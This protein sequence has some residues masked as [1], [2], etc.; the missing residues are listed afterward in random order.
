MK[1]PENTSYYFFDQ[2]GAVCKPN[3]GW[4]SIK[5]DNY[6]YW[7]YIR[8]ENQSEIVGT[9]IIV[10]VGMVRCI[11]EAYGQAQM[12]DMYMMTMVIF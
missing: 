6:T 7:Y 12:K 5:S 4:F 11:P 10:S 2:D 9:M 3:D 1:I 8:M